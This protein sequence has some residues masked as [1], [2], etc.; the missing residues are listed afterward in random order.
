VSFLD[1]SLNARVMDNAERRDEIV[2]LEA[3]IEQ[4]AQ[5][6]ESCAKFILLSRIAIA[7]GGVFLLATVFGAIRF[8]PMVMIAAIA[9]VLGGIVSLGSNKSTSDQAAAAMQAAEL[10][11]G[12][13][14]STINLH[15]VAGSEQT[16]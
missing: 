12:E 11:R 8:D 2:D 4:L 16:R 9:A 7:V 15:V 3:R 14:I 5:A 6:I 1:P 13:L 10:R